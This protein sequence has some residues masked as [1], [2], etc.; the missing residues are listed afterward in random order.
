MVLSR[1]MRILIEGNVDVGDHGQLKRRRAPPRWRRLWL[2]AL[3]KRREVFLL[4]SPKPDDLHP[5]EAPRSEMIHHRQTA[6]MQPIRHLFR[7]TQPLRDLLG[8][9]ATLFTRLTSGRSRIYHTTMA[10]Q[11]VSFTRKEHRSKAVFNSF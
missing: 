1:P 3:D 6:E 4:D 2:R 5:F 10:R 8:H 11:G 7:G 9:D